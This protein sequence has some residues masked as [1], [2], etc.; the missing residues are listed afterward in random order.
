MTTDDLPDDDLPDDDLTDRLADLLT[1]SA[2]AIDVHP[3]LDAVTDAP[4]VISLVADDPT[5]HGR[6]RRTL[7]HPLRRLALGAV[8]AA[9]VVA[10]VAAALTLGDDDPAESVASA[11]ATTTTT[12][13]LAAPT[14][15]VYPVVDEWPEGFAT[16]DAVTQD[17]GLGSVPG[18][19][20]VIGT[21]DG[22]GVVEG[23]TVQSFLG[24]SNAYE[25]AERTP[26]TVGGRDAFTLET[27]GHGGEPR[28]PTLLLRDG[29]TL[30]VLSGHDPVGLIEA[31]P[32]A[33][34]AQ[35]D[36]ERVELVIGELPAPFEVVSETPPS[37][38][39][40]WP[41]LLSSS[42][43]AGNPPPQV[44]IEVR[45]GDPLAAVASAGVARST[46]ASGVPGWIVANEGATYLAREVTEG[47][48]MVV[49][50][51][52]DA[53]TVLTVAD[54]TRFVDRATWEDIYGIDVDARTSSTETTQPVDPTTT[55]GE[56]S[57]S[58]PAPAWGGWLADHPLLGQPL[59]P[60]PVDGADVP[61]PAGR[62]TIVVVGS[63][64]CTACLDQ[65]DD[66]D[67]VWEERPAAQAHDVAFVAL[68]TDADELQALREARDGGWL[69]RPVDGS[70]LDRWSLRA[71][72][73]ILVV[74]PDR[75]VHAVADGPVDAM[76]A[77]TRLLGAE[78]EWSPGSPGRGPSAT[79]QYCSD[80]DRVTCTTTC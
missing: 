23:I 20:A 7:L 50:G 49:S 79:A 17:I 11:G 31:A 48:T 36:G 19:S 26:V 8:A 29:E 27:Y 43:G 21:T 53:D 54:A 34:T 13:A 2:D 28:S 22:D 57:T 62:W 47:V 67:A 71:V 40:M 35:V 58:S 78:A 70:L 12:A 37:D 51:P 60:M 39:R 66:L 3:D 80:P 4:T 73:A 6:G 65:L 68:E 25:L 38:E 5:G 24:S 52:V 32:D 63:P 69:P 1:R 41:S 33:V 16:G 10:L 45:P 72:P 42:T 18:P 64:A 56:V 14:G 44:F 77:Y 59:P 76:T 15:D 46:E 9:A 75:T 55:G 61:T 30:L 74:G